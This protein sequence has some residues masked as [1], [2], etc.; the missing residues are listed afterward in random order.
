MGSKQ[1]APPPPDPNAVSAAQTQS[2]VNTALDN[3]SLNRYNTN[4]PLGNQS[5][6]IS[7]YTKDASG[8]KI[9]QYTQTNTLT[10]T[11]QQILDT[12]QGNQLTQANTEKG[13]LGHV[14]NQL[15]NPLTA[16]QFGPVQSSVAGVDLNNAQGT[17][18][19]QQEYNAQMSLIAPQ[20]QQDTQRAQDALRAEGIPEGSD[21]WNTQMQNVG[22]SQAAQDAGITSNAA[23]LGTTEQ[24]NL[25]NQGA[26]QGTFTNAAE[27]Q[28]M[29]QGV[30][31]QNQPLNELNALSTGSQ[32][33]TPTFQ[34]TPGVNMAGTNTSG[35]AYASYQGNVNATNANN[36][37]SNAIYGDLTSLGGALGGAAIMSDKRAKKDIEPA[38]DLPMYRFR[39]KGESK[40]APKR[41]GVM[42]QDAEKVMPDAVATGMD[43]YKLVMYAKLLG[44]V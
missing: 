34:S 24:N 21:L 37:A 15:Q 30:A 2:N 10:K 39:Y 28:K 3:A 17:G 27:A 19:M 16:D 11:G 14:S 43:G 42:A 6:T 1:S 20:Q 40:G 35:N 4:T 8:N 12:S 32:V 18:A 36:A 9:P 41:L 25:F 22:R 29:Q 5:W 26:S 13:F 31:L 7:G 33:A 38:T 44:A 23:Q